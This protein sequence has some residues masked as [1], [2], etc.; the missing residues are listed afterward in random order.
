M[1]W[2]NYLFL[3]S[4][5]NKSPTALAKELGITS[6]TVSGWKKGKIPKENNL[7]KI[8][9]YFGLTIWDLLG[10]NNS[11]S[12]NTESEEKNSVG[13]LREDLRNNYAFRVLYDVTD[14][15]TEADLL[16]AAALVQ[17]RKEERNR[18]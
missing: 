1:F 5:V 17:R 8:A 2:I 11:P 6:G 12:E 9:D 4:Q 13:E 14:G 15:A 3:C 10:E 7:Q 18:G 16:E